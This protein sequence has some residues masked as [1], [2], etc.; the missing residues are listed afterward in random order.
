MNA[1]EF[2]EARVA[3]CDP[4]LRP[5]QTRIPDHPDQSEF[6]ERWYDYHRGYRIVVHDDGSETRV[7][8]L[9]EPLKDTTPGQLPRDL[10][11]MRRSRHTE[12][13]AIPLTLDSDPNRGT[14]EGQT[15]VI[16]SS[17]PE[18]EPETVNPERPRDEISALLNYRSPVSNTILADQTM[19]TE[20]QA[21]RVATLRREL[22]RMRGGIERVMTGLRELGE[23]IPETGNLIRLP[24]PQNDRARLGRSG[25]G[26]DALNRLE[27]PYRA[28]RGTPEHDS[29][30]NPNSI[31]AAIQQRLSEAVANLDRC[32]R[33]RERAAD[34]LEASE[35]HVQAARERVR[36][37]ERE[38]RTAENYSQVFGTR[39]EIERQ[40]ADYESPIGGM[41]NRAWGRY[42]EREEARRREQILRDVLAAEE[43]IME[44]T[45]H[46]F[47]GTEIRQPPERGA[48]LDREEQA[49]T[50]YYAGLRDQGWAQSSDRQSDRLPRPTL[51][52]RPGDDGSGNDNSTS[53]ADIDEANRSMQL[54]VPLET[55]MHD[56]M[57]PPP[58]PI[59][60]GLG[61]D[62][63]RLN[64]IRV[65]GQRMSRLISM[66]QNTPRALA[67]NDQDP[68]SS[69]F[70]EPPSAAD[71]DVPGR[72]LD[73]ADDDRPPPKDDAEMNVSLECKVC[74]TQM[75]DTAVLPCGH[76][77]MCRWCAEV[78]VGPTLSHDRTRPRG[79]ANC[80]VCRRRVKQ[81]V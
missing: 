27:L 70:R 8:M 32:R 38:R 12:E 74:Y 42:R 61:P 18:P 78:H 14:E 59:G 69:S 57:T 7:P 33:D 47:D 9:G 60:S 53:D 21:R 50:E 79:A 30:S 67:L 22:Q 6:L 10:D 77:V 75:A 55:P 15:G 19:R 71:M 34:E 20:Y 49:L 58:P 80:P 62:S 37:I 45:N 16:R 56:S 72:G 2:W 43:R 41:F 63:T 11:E 3:A 29:E 66:L 23:E 81:K 54:E 1:T 13:E 65:Q 44:D 40:G 24:W 35:G 39:E 5:A 76:L 31:M 73:N 64:R 28:F 68:S 52:E 36:R 26:Q 25:T 17:E 46:E 51:P 48:L 4:P